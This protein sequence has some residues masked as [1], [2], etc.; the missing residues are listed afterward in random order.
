MAPVVKAVKNV[1]KATVKTVGKVVKAV[2]Q[3][4]IAVIAAVAAPP[5]GAAIGLSAPV[6]IAATNAA[7][8]LATTGDIGKAIIS[9]AA[10]GV[11]EVVGQAVG[12][13]LVKDY[14]VTT[15][16]IVGSAAKSAT[17]TA[18]AT[19][20][21]ASAIFKGAIAGAA[22]SAAGQAVGTPGV[23]NAL[24]DTA[25]QAVEKAAQ[26]A[27]IAAVMGGDPGAAAL[28][29]AGGS[30]LSSA[31]QGLGGDKTTAPAPA[32]PPGLAALPA[33]Q[34]AEQNI[35]YTAGT[36][37]GAVTTAPSVEVTAP[38]LDL[39]LADTT[40]ALLNLINQDKAKPA[41]TPAAIQQSVAKDVVDKLK[42]NG[43][44]GYVDEAGRVV[45]TAMAPELDL[46][47]PGYVFDAN[48]YDSSKAKPSGAG[49]TTPS[50]TTPSTTT[51]SATKPSTEQ[52]P[53]VD[54]TAKRETDITAPPVD[55]TAKSGVDTTGGGTTTYF[56][57]SE[58]SPQ[59]AQILKLIGVTAPSSKG[60]ASQ[61]ARAGAQ[62]PTSSL[63]SAEDAD[64][65]ALFG[66][67]PEEL[68]D[69]WNQSSLRLRSA[70]GI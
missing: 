22:G 38:R 24:G 43:G 60:G 20:G 39:D 4:P 36:P 68:Q 27:A 58:V 32:T 59:D 28:I 57:P 35:Q 46:V 66:G 8:T 13:S 51:P 52:A 48:L 15:A 53:A 45:V 16:K 18:I 3:N 62:A 64:L 14:G 7:V 67:K 56:G 63:I 12:G 9:G 55:V 21:D 23:Y 41:T 50:A 34:G 40:P 31:T 6:A 65:S 10:A 25:G 1:V 5:L 17:Q 42:Q 11:G 49:A 69:V 44:D 29:G 37:P 54:V 61:V 30:L 47:S 33:G 70:L 26:N 19:G 2:A